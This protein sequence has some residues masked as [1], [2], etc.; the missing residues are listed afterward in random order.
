[1]IEPPSAEELAALQFNLRLELSEGKVRPFA[2]FADGKIMDS[3]EAVEF[4][5][6]ILREA[7]NV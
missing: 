2:L 5:E 6:N 4:I 7:C 1:M 3:N